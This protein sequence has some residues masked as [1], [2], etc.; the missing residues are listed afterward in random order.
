MHF[1]CIIDLYYNFFSFMDIKYRIRKRT[2]NGK[3][4]FYVDYKRFTESSDPYDCPW[5]GGFYAETEEEARKIVE[6][7]REYEQLKERLQ[8]TEDVIYDEMEVKHD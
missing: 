1:F 2:A 4:Q 6:K 5:M 8:M 7:H 3:D